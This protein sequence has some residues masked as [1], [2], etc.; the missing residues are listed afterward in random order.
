MVVVIQP[1]LVGFCPSS[2]IIAR[3]LADI[4]VVDTSLKPSI[5]ACTKSDHLSSFLVAN[6]LVITVILEFWV[7]KR[8]MGGN[9]VTLCVHC[10]AY[11][12]QDNHCL[13]DVVRDTPLFYI[14]SDEHTP[15]QEHKQPQTIQYKQSNTHNIY[16]DHEHEQQL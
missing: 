14:H 3:L 16:Q 7:Q 13:G 2:E 4:S 12:I 6:Y 15:Y 11:F 1:C 8:Q 5:V 10:S 9:A